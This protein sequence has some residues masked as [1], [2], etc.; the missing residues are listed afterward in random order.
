MWLASFHSV[1]SDLWCFVWRVENKKLLVSQIAAQIPEN[2]SAKSSM[3]AVDTATERPLEL[4]SGT[5]YTNKTPVTA[6]IREK[7]RAYDV[8]IV[9]N[10]NLTR[11]EWLLY[12]IHAV[13][14]SIALLA[15]AMSP[16]GRWHQTLKAQPGVRVSI[17]PTTGALMEWAPTA[18]VGQAGII[19]QVSPEQTVIVQTVSQDPDGLYRE[20]TLTMSQWKELGPVFTRFRV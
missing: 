5:V 11:I 19:R 12:K 4:V 18:D 15:L 16:V 6:L 17:E 3:I 9:K 1:L 13:D 8:G 2:L 10:A 7:L 20:Q 14:S